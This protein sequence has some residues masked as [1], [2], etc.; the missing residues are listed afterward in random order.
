MNFNISRADIGAFMVNQI[1][2][3][4]YIYAMPIIGS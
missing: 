2:S 1:E 3:D 4:K